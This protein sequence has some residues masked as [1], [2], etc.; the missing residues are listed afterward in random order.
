MRA[1]FGVKSINMFQMNKVLSKHIW[2]LASDDGILYKCQLG[3]SFYPLFW[4]NFFFFLLLLLYLC[5]NSAFGLAH[6]FNDPNGVWMD[7]PNFLI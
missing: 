7:S 3:Y 2:P 1:L 6:G 5:L 4:C